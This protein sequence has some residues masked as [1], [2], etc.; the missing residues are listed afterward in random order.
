MKILFRVLMGI[1]AICGSHALIGST[2]GQLNAD[3]YDLEETLDINNGTVA[4]TAE[5]TLADVF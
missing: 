2:A 5:N 4:F 1:A 3:Q